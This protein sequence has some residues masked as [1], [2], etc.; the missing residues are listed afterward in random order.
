MPTR[1]T[2]ER[3]V[4]CLVVSGMV[5]GTRL[6]KTEK[7]NETEGRAMTGRPQSHRTTQPGGGP[8]HHPNPDDDVD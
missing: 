2:K 8:L 1:L 5:S 4:P 6:P 3:V 7:R